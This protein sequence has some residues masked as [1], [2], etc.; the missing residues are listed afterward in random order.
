MQK[1]IIL[2]S[3]FISQLAIAGDAKLGEA[4]S[5]MCASCHGADGNSSNPM[6]PTIAGQHEDYTI[7]QLKLFKN[8]ERKGTVM[9][10]MVAALNESDMQNLAAFY[11]SK[12]ANTGSADKSLVELGKSIYQGG[13]KKLNIPACMACHGV[14][15][16]GNPLSGYPVL[17]GQHAAYTEQRLKAYKAGEKTPDEDDVNGKIMADIAKYLENDEIKAVANYIQGL[18]SK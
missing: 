7:R 12:K 10:G 6:W 8:G 16:K 4:K 5:V 13:K 3:L 11:V 14:A 15:G 18:Y 17:A 1:A 2:I 9:A